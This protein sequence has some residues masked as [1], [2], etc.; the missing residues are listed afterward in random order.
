MNIQTPNLNRLAKECVECWNDVRVEISE[1]YSGYE[2]S[3]FAG[4]AYQVIASSNSEIGALA[5][6]DDPLLPL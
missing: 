2:A 3:L 1:D 5:L 6:L 4:A